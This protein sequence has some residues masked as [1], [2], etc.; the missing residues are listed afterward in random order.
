MKQRVSGGVSEKELASFRMPS[1]WQWL[2]RMQMTSDP[3]L[4]TTV[5]R[6]VMGIITD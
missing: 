4:R 5:G 2:K 3:H 1:S 6:K